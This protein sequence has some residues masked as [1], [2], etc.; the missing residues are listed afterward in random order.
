LLVARSFIICCLF[1]A[2]ITRQSPRPFPPLHL[3]SLLEHV[4]CCLSPRP[5]VRATPCAS[6]LAQYHILM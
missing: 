1:V 6:A 2:W 5:F 3:A 4:D